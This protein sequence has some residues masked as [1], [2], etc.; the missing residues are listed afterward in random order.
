[1]GPQIIIFPGD[2]KLAAAAAVVVY[3]TFI[4]LALCEIRNRTEK[5]IFF[6]KAVCK[7]Y[8]HVLRFS[9]HSFFSVFM[10]QTFLNKEILLWSL[11]L[12]SLP[13]PPAT[14]ATSTR[15]A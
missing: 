15:Y 10:I 7:F 1:V 5:C 6:R 2:E 14:T 11:N 8:G 12:Q 13:P 3:T 4:L 9:F